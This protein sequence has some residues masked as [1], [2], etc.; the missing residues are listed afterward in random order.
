MIRP[1][2]VLAADA[3]AEATPTGSTKAT[4]NNWTAQT[5]VISLQLRSQLTEGEQK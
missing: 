2:V 5:L 4:P 3:P 1:V